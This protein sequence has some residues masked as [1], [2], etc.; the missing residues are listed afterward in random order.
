MLKYTISTTEP[1]YF[2]PVEIETDET[3][4]ALLGFK[5]SEKKIDYNLFPDDPNISKL[6][7]S[8]EILSQVLVDD[9]NGIAPENSLVRLKNYAKGHKSKPLPFIGYGFPNGH[10]I[11]AMAYQNITELYFRK[12]AKARPSLALTKAAMLE[13]ENEHKYIEDNYI[14]YWVRWT[15][16]VDFYN[17]LGDKQ[18]IERMA[19]E[20][21]KT[22]GYIQYTQFALAIKNKEFSQISKFALSEYEGIRNLEEDTYEYNFNNLKPIAI[23]LLAK[24]DYKAQAIEIGKHLL[25]EK[26]RIGYGEKA[27]IALSDLMDKNEFLETIKPFDQI[28]L[29]SKYANH[30]K[31]KEG[32][33]FIASS[34]NGKPIDFNDIFISMIG[35]KAIND[36][37]LNETILKNWQFIGSPPPQNLLHTDFTPDGAYFGIY[38][39]MLLIADKPIEAIENY[40][41]QPLTAIYWDL[42]HGYGFK[43]IDKY[44]KYANF[45]EDLEMASARCAYPNYDYIENRAD[46]VRQHAKYSLN[47]Q[48]SDEE[49]S[50]IN[51]AP[52]NPPPYNNSAAGLIIISAIQAAE[53][54]KIYDMKTADEMIEIMFKAI[55]KSPDHESNFYI[56]NSLEH[57]AIA[58]LK[59]QNRLKAN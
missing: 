37:S 49:L 24:N 42:T 45:T 33:Q 28:A 31:L 4:L 50:F 9:A 56:S 17:E 53:Y 18:S 55:E 44:A 21:P 8:R 47:R 5:K 54:A 25:S 34:A 32:E 27:I 15:E 1:N 22:K 38:H 30:P 20:Q 46:C 2:I 58:K 57:Y 6:L 12:K 10:E 51:D 43:N 14:H 39:K 23:Q 48:F 59:Q 7:K 19:K 26:Y 40:Q 36:N 29:I 13:W 41:M 35:H 16:L 11:R 3:I 52:H